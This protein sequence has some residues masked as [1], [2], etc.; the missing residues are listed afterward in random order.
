[1]RVVHT[2]HSPKLGS[3]TATE[4]PSNPETAPA[5]IGCTVATAAELPAVKALSG[6]FLAHHPEARF[7][8]LVV[9]A[10]PGTSGPGLVTPADL[11]VTAE[12]LAVLATRCTAP[13][14]CGVLR[15]LL[16]AQLLGPGVP[17]RCLAPWV[18]V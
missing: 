5:L 3:Y 4:F 11:G 17:V 6:S 18:R 1:M 8:A 13:E 15:P 7:L 12:E 9:D 10:A 16:Q 2:G 14:R